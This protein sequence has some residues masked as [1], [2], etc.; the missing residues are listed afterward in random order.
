M[1]CVDEG[2][3]GAPPVLLVHGLP[4]WSYLYRKVVPVLVDAGFRVVAPDLVGFGRSDKPTERTD[5]TLERHIGWLRDL[6]SQLALSDVTLLCHDWGG[7]TGLGVLAAEPGRFA[8]VLVFNTMLHTGEAELAGRLGEGYSAHRINDSEVAMGV[9]LLDWLA[10]SQRIPGFTASTGVA[11]M[12]D[13]LEGQEDVLA[14]YDAPFPDERYKAGVRQFPLLNPFSP[15]DKNRPINLHTWEVLRSF[16]KPFLTAYSDSDPATGGWDRIFQERVPG[17]AG[18]PH[19]TFEG[20][21]HFLPE[22]RPRE[23]A[24]LAIDFIRRT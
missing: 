17:A 15:N 14:A 20:A 24:E 22:E 7:P 4:T 16:E 13:A 23:L 3:R 1:H 2:P 12:C 19:V 11:R 10:G 6:V 18:R 9:R 8:R 5:Y 21:R